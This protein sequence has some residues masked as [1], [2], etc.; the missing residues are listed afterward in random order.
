M[1]TRTAIACACL[2]ILGSGATFAGEPAALRQAGKVDLPGYTGD[3]DH[4]GVD[5]AGKRLFLAAEDHGT[6]EVF[7]LASG[8]H[9][10][11]VAGVEQ[12]HGILY[13]EDKNRLVVTDSG[14]GYTKI[15]D[16]RS[17]KMVGSIK[18]TKGADSMIYDPAG[19]SMYVVAGGKNGGLPTSELVR[20]DPRT[21][22]TLASHP[23]DTDKVEAMAVEQKGKRLYVNVTGKNEVAVLDKNTLELLQA[24]PV[25]GGQVNAAMA[26]DEANGRLFIVTRQ[27]YMMQVLDTSNGKSVASF[28]APGRTNEAIY[29]ARN[30][31]IYLAGDHFINVV[32]Q[33]GADEYVA[34]E[35]V[36]TAKGAKTAIFVPQLNRLYAAVSTGED[37]NAMATVLRFDVPAAKP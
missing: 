11:T 7:D 14:D 2:L 32:Q 4:F 37:K 23:F 28:P 19:K 9:L 6:L 5:V 30:H 8:K 34:L 12:P 33:K 17:Y 36:P 25:S 31:R 35:P 18:L 26:F 22:K 21:G 16:A 3:F 29:D 20:V 15:F 13:L 27:P 10:K 24:W 1:I